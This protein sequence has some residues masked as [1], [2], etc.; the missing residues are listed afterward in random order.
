MHGHTTVI[1]K[2]NIVIFGGETKKEFYNIKDIS[3]KTYFYNFE[4]NEWKKI[5][6]MEN[7][8]KRRSHTANVIGRK[9]IVCG[10]YN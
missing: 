10:G 1:Y 7:V 4:N 6:H 2:K 5:K 9:M 8:I 3:N